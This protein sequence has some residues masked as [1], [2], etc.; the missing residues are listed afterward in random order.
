M[1]NYISQK[2][3][4]YETDNKVLLESNENYLCIHGRQVCRISRAI[5]FFPLGK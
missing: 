5:R 1:P 4:R 2:K 3:E